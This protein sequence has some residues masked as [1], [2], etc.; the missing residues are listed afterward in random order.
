MWCKLGR[1]AGY[2][3]LVLVLLGLCTY[4][5]QR[6]VR[7]LLGR[8]VSTWMSRGLNGTLEIGTLRGS[9][10][11][12]V[13]LRDVVLRDQQGVEVVRLDEVRLRY[14]LTALFTPRLVVKRVD[15]VRPRATL[16]QGPGGAWNIGHVL[17][18]LF[19]AGRSPAPGRAAG[20]EL[21]LAV[22]V[23]RVQI[24]DGEIAVQTP[25]LPGVQSLT[26]LQ[27]HLQGQ[28]DTHGFYVQV[29]SLT[30]RTTPADVVLHTVQGTIQGDTT[31]IRI[32]AFRLQTAQTLVTVDGILPGS[33]QPASLTLHMQPFDVAELGYLL[34]RHDLYGLLSLT[35]TAQGP[36]EALSVRGQLNTAGG[37]LDLHGQLDT[38]A[39][40]W[41]YS[42]SLALTHVNLATLLHHEPLQ[43]DL[44]LH[45]HL[46]GAGLAPAAWRGAVRLDIQ[47]SAVGSITLQPSGL[48]VA[49]QPGRVQVHYCDLRTSVARLTATGQLDLTGSSALQY[50][51]TADLAGLRALLRTETLDGIL[52]LRGQASGE[53]TAL[54]VQGTL[55]G[56]RLRYATHRLAKLHLLFA[57]AQLGEH[58]HLTARLGMH[59]ARV[60]SVPL[61]RAN[62]DATYD[63]ST[64]QLRVVTEVV[65]SAVYSGRARGTLTWTETGQQIVVDELLVRLADHPWRTL[66]PIKML[67]SVQGLRLTQ[68]HMAHADEAL[69][70]SGAFDGQHFQDVH[71]R[72]TQ[73]DLTFVR[74]LVP[75]PEL[76]QGRATWQAHLSGTLAAPLLDM[77][78]TLRP[79]PQQR[80]PFD[81]I[82]VT[83]AYAHQQLQ[84]EVR[85]RQANREVL[86]VA[87]RLP[88]DL[89][90]TAVPL[91]Q[92]LLAAGA[93]A[94]A[95]GK[96]LPVALHVRLQ[97]PDLAAVSRWQPMLP[98]LSGTLQGDLNVQG[99][100]AALDF[101]ADVRLQQWGLQGR[102]EQVSAPLRLQGTLGLVPPDQGTAPAAPR[103]IFPRIQKAVL[104][105]PTLRGQL[106]GQDQPPRVFQAQDFVLQ[107]AGQWTAGGFDGTIERLQTQVRVTGWPR[108]EVS[109]AGRLTPQRFD[110]TRLQV[111]LPQSEV[112]ATGSLTLPQQ[113]VQ[114]RLD[115][116]RLQLD[117]VGFSPPVPLLP[118]LQGVIEV[119]G[120]VLAPQVEARLQYAG[121]QLSARLAAQLQ[122]PTPR[123]SATLHADNLNVAHLLSGA[124]GTLRARL[125]IQGTGFTASQRRAEVELRLET[126]GLTLAPDLTARLQGSLRGNRVQIEEAQVRSALG[127]MVARGTLSTTATT[128]AQTSLTYDMTLAD[129]TPLQRY[130][131]VSL[132]AKGSLSGTVQGTWPA[133]KAHHRLQLRDWGYGAWHGQ[134]V[135]AELAIAHFPTAPQATVK[136]Q[137]VD[138]QGPALSRSSLTLTGTSTSSQGTARLSVTAGPYY[139]TGL[140]G[141]FTWAEEQRLTLT[142][143]RLQHKELVWENATPITVMRDPQGKLALHRLLLRSGRQ[144]VRAQGILM[145][146]GRLEADV[147]VQHLRLLPHV[148]VVA[149]AMGPVDGEVA[150]HLSLRGTLSQPQGEAR[151]HATSLRWQQHALGEIHGQLRADGTTVGV[152]LHW[153]DQKRE[154]LHL[155]GHIGLDTRQELAVQ[156][157][158]TDVDLQVLTAFSPA[159][160]QSA[161]TLQVDLR[162]AGTLQQP[163]AYGTLRLDDGTL[164]LTATGVQ[165]R[166]IQAQ[167]VCT[168]QRVELTRL[169][170]V[171]GAGSLELTGWAESARLTLP[172][173]ELVLRMHDYT[174][175]YTPE[176]EAVVSAALTLR[177]SLEEMVATGTVVVPRARAQLS[178]KL[179]GAPEVVQPWQLTV[180]GVY[181]SGPPK[182]RPREVTSTA[183]QTPSW[184]FLRTDVQ[185]QLPRNV[186]V[187]GH[188]TAIELNGVLTVAKELGAPFVLR[189][190][191]ETVR[192]FTSFYSGKFV[193]EQGRVTFTGSPGIDPALD[194]TVTRAVAGYV[195]A[196]NVIG[197]AKSPQLRLS[198]TPDLPQADIVTLL[199][200][201]KTTDHLTASERSGL[202]DRAQQIVG[203]VPASDLERLL[204]R[205]LGLDTLDIQTGDKL[206]SGKVSVGRYVTQD[207]FLSYERRRGEEGGNKVGIEYSINHH[208]K[209]KGSSSDTGDS[210][211]DVLWRIDY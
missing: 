15:I 16:V 116:S 183:R 174:L 37:R 18:P 181:G 40:P 85:L 143:F 147:Q 158:A 1:M 135:Q 13:V 169:H 128:L 41:R 109:V 131:G 84:S 148:R 22:V 46:E 190:T 17:A 184:A 95:Q 193:L 187:R 35:L 208:L 27:A 67:R 39:T 172:R 28:I 68:F 92:R 155:Y 182:T 175:M 90:C 71:M 211:V 192:G 91:E 210:A 62:V 188:G 81:R 61:E 103:R 33:H 36:P 55:E 29:H 65:Q 121:G 199:V 72:A 24:H 144:E 57:G 136:V 19:P 176:L 123:Y 142:H 6:P 59:Q 180:D 7:A 163:Q 25:A 5:A 122:A 139:K 108:A 63:S 50:D 127:T 26:G 125:H 89:A 205:P 83:L 78:V 134:R 102:V 4:V 154:L 153:R 207:I 93:T 209:V 171:S 146:E 196:V 3:G 43:S 197:R 201:G 97:Q 8:T 200:V 149:P 179:V 66:A 185:L 82:E 45:L 141:R 173:L 162:L 117:E 166:A 156:V 58:P 178:G 2:V 206:G 56:Q 9:L 151:L 94:S 76:V 77:A 124:Q 137:A 79:E 157:Q 112:R 107:A 31:A 129:L 159:V 152:D 99:T 70:L 48:H 168:G 49:V 96:A 202:S 110:L 189:G 52:H 161:G 167:I 170:A 11:S 133:L 44:N 14:D 104:R 195:V 115:V 145:P 12:A 203:N 101:D 20:G 88:V 138:V 38:V 69:E 47:P 80:L 51:L 191:V 106:P 53:G 118:L 75:L 64:A 73:F 74:R 194:V 111:R 113:H 160:V 42:T 34:Q 10:F 87:A 204:A 119:G 100:Y 198:S 60:G 164:Q 105:M 54:S 98:G 177:G 165:Y 86:R 32:D 150:L 130:L 21:P 114:L 186:W 23:Q 132:Q 30:G 126:S 140:E 120:S